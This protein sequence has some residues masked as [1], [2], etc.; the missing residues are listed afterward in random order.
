MAVT[1]NK[2]DLTVTAGVPAIQSQPLAAKR[3]YVL[4]KTVD[5]TAGAVVTTDIYQCLAIPAYTKVQ[6]VRVKIIT[7]AVGTTLTANV[8]SAGGS[9]W[10]AA[11]D[12]KAV[13]GT[14]TTS[15]VGTDAEAAAAT[16][17][18][19]YDTADTIDVTMVTV[20]AITAGPK[21]T[22]YADCVDYSS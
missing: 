8:G 21:F 18:T 13:A 1:F 22:I 20:T 15:L 17:G 11:I 10:D 9:G 16:Q 5:L 3:A 6:Q 19:I 14:W 12:L 7:P 4:Q 2:T